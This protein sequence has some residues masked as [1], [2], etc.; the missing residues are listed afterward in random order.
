MARPP[1]PKVSR[2]HKRRLSSQHYRQVNSA[3]YISII[4]LQVY[5]LQVSDFLKKNSWYFGKTGISSFLLGSD[6]TQV[7]ASHG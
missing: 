6:L 4:S 1:D 7:Y 5:R 2:R 3:F